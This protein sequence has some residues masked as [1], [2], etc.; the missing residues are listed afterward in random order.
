MEKY[1]HFCALIIT[2]KIVLS[3]LIKE[4]KNSNYGVFIG[5]RHNQES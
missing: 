3:S 1:S 2:F 4:N 5:V